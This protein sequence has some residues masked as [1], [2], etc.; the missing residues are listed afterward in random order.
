MQRSVRTF[1]AVE[2]SSEVRIRAGRLIARLAAAGADVRWVKPEHMHLTLKFLGDVDLREMPDVCAA[3]A[4][5]VSPLPPFNLRIAGTGAF[6]NATNPRTVWL[7]ADE[8]VEEIAELEE[9]IGVAL[10]DLGFR[11]EQRRFRPHLTIGRVRH[12]DQGMNELAQVLEEHKDYLAGVI[13][14]DEV[15]TL[16]SELDRSG[17][18]HEPLATAALQGE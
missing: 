3:V 4:R 16:S 6:P 2:I 7:G 9:R 12:A 11:R 1:I 18:T 10:A 13:D 14:V 15:V 8:G 5:A 17:P